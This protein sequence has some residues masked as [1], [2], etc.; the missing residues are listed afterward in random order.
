[1]RFYKSRYL[2]I[3]I[4]IVLLSSS[5]GNY[6]K[7]DEC[8]VLKPRLSGEYSG[9]CRKGLAHGFGKAT[10][11]DQYIGNFKKGLP[12][13]DGKYIWDSGEIYD[14]SWKNG[15]REGYGIYSFNINGQDTSLQG[16]WEN[17]KYVG[18]YIYPYKTI[19]LRQIKS[20]RYFKLDDVGDRIDIEFLQQGKADIEILS[21]LLYGNSGHSEVELPS[22]VSFV[23]IQFPFEGRIFFTTIKQTLGIRIYCELKFLIYE[24]GIWRIRIN[25]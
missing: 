7:Q 24:P 22:P 8:K 14:G 5:V 15:M 20:V 25:T 6:V 12:H 23:D 18:Q 1:M 4:G 11:Q 2:F 21:V 17:D 16:Y 9:K 10:G 3:I 19:S 13:G